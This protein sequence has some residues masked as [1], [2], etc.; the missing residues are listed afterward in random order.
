MLDFLVIGHAYGIPKNVHL[1][2]NFSAFLK[3]QNAEN[4]SNVG[5][6]FAGDVFHTSRP[7]K[8]NKLLDD[9]PKLVI[10]TGNHELSDGIMAATSNLITNKN[11]AKLVFIAVFQ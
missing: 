1:A 8:W 9:L 5:I 11:L 6:V 7:Q 4:L 10:A 2:E 3:K